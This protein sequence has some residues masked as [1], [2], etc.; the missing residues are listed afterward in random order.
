MYDDIVHSYMDCAQ[1]SRSVVPLKK[2][3]KKMCVCLK[4]LDRSSHRDLD[5]SPVILHIHRQM[6]HYS[7]SSRQGDMDR[8]QCS[9][10]VC[11]LDIGVALA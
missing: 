9:I 6:E 4:M 7:W 2:K 3:L 1:L 11:F 5:Q 10:H 8:S